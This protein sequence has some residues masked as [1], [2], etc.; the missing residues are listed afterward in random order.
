MII[1]NQSVAFNTPADD[2]PPVVLCSKLIS[3]WRDKRL[4]AVTLL[5]RSKGSIQENSS[6]PRAG[7]PQL[8]HLLR[9]VPVSIEL[10]LNESLHLP[11]FMAYVL[12]DKKFAL[13]LICGMANLVG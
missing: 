8:L 2:G 5:E 7:I 13:L 3:V 4:T 11:P 6:E 1:D 12:M 10:L 9:E